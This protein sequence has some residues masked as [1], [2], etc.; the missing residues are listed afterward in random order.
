[1]PKRYGVWKRALT[2]NSHNFGWNLAKSLAMLH[3]AC[4]N[5]NGLS[6]MVQIERKFFLS[7]TIVEPTNQKQRLKIGINAKGNKWDAK[8]TMPA[9][10]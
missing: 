10:E 9:A 7:T 2:I 4:R 8:S 6:A 3:A 1:M 5:T